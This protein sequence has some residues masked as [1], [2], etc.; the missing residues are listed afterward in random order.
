MYIRL[1]GRAGFALQPLALREILRLLNELE[2]PVGEVLPFFHL[3]LL[4][5]FE[6]GTGLGGLRFAPG[7]HAGEADLDVVDAERTVLQTRLALSQVEAQQRI[8]LAILAKA[9]GGGWSGK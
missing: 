2:D 6:E 3:K 5:L 1:R 7:R 8:S 4:V 9:L